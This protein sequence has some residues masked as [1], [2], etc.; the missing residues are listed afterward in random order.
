MPVAITTFEEEPKV[1]HRLMLFGEPG[2]GKTAALVRAEAD[3]DLDIHEVLL[4]KAKPVGD[5]G[6]LFVSS[7]SNGLQTAK[8]FNPR[9]RLAKISTA[10]DLREV[11][12]MANSGELEELGIRQVSIDGATEVQRL[13][14]DAIKGAN[15]LDKQREGRDADRFDQDDWGYLNEKMRGWFRFMRAMQ[16]DVVCSALEMVFENK[17]TGT[18]HVCPS[19][20]GTKIPK[21]A[22]G[23]FE[24]VGRAG[25]QEMSTGKIRYA[26]QFELAGRYKV[27]SCGAL[28]GTVKPCAAAWLAV[29]DG[30]LAATQIMLSPATS[31]AEPSPTESAPKEAAKE[32]PKSRSPRA[33]KD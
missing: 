30:R 20:E 25:K 28:K 15:Q 32:T 11:M 4:G 31:D 3:L 29:L 21:E 16:V 10:T 18:I 6:I 17:Q 24:A 12:E 19:F 33:R 14:K 2:T 23:Y 26:A 1:F 7:E 27:K 13:L 5:P 9:V 8:L 22:G